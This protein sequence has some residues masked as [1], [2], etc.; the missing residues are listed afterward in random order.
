MD[1]FTIG[2]EA[3]D[4]WIDL[5]LKQF[6]IPIKTLTDMKFIGY[7]DLLIVY[8]VSLKPAVYV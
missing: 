6:I 3:I 2:V 7:N 4:Q 1:V 8:Y 5:N